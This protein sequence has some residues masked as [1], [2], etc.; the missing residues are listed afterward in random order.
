M[1]TAANTWVKRLALTVL[2]SQIAITVTGSL[3]RVTGSGLGCNTWPNCHEGSLVPVEGAA[4]WINQIIEFGNR[5][6]AIIL[7]FLVLALLVAVYKANRSKL[8]KLHAWYQFAGV[9]FQ[10]ILGGISVRLDLQWWSVALH[11]LPSMLLIWLAVLLYEHVKE[12]DEGVDQWMYPRPLRLLTVGSAVS[13]VAVLVT[14]TMVTGAGVHSGDKG[15][16]MEGR[17]NVPIIEIAHIHAHFMY[18]YLGLTIGLVVALFTVKASEKARKLGV[19]LIV[20]ILV[21]AAVGLIQYWF[22]IPSWTIPVHVALSGIVTA[23]TAWLYAAGRE[24]VA[25]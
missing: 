2:I 22:G 12:S 4:P 19:M 25:A 5:G 15:I 7:G 13:L 16:G 6:L 8:I 24:R 9:I 21:Q 3:V 11:F 1:N 23:Y 17:L 10:G 20:L 18:L 14:G